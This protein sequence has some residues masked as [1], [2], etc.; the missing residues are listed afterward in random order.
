MNEAKET[1]AKLKAEIAALRSL[2]PSRRRGGARSGPR[3]RQTMPSY[4]AGVVAQSR[5]GGC[6]RYDVAQRPTDCVRV[7]R[8]TACAPVHRPRG[9]I[10][11]SGSDPMEEEK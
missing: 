3:T 10:R 7:A 9:S 1:P 8:C 2:P 11:K 4:A 6:G 5:R